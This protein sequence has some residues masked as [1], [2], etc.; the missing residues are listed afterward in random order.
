MF[1]LGIGGVGNSG[2]CMS[3]SFRGHAGFLSTKEVR[4]SL[5]LGCERSGIHRLG[6]FCYTLWPPKT[7]NWI[8]MSFSFG[9][10]LQIGTCAYT[11][12]PRLGC[13]LSDDA[14]VMVPFKD[15]YCLRWLPDKV[16]SRSPNLN[17][18]CL[19]ERVI[20]KDCKMLL[21]KIW[22]LLSLCS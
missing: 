17:Y 12:I 7:S 13:L 22:K 14:K 20:V 19:A 4:G 11:V 5:A 2:G 16:F 1:R 10:D 6:C 9:M 3:V 18:C 15:F 21:Q 8:Y